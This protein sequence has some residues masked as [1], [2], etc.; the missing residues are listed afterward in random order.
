[1]NKEKVIC[2]RLNDKQ[3]EKLE[4]KALECGMKLSTYIRDKALKAK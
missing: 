1:M 2:V 3:L 4:K